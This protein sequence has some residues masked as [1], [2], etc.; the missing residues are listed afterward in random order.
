MET[1]HALLSFSGARSSMHRVSPSVIRRAI[2][3][4]LALVALAGCASPQRKISF[5][6]AGF[7]LA[8][9]PE[10]VGVPPP[11]QDPVPEAVASEAPQGPPIDPIL[12]RFASEARS[13]RWRHATPSPPHAG[14]ESRREGAFPTEAILAWRGLT[15]D[16][17]QYLRL[18]LP[19]TPLLELIRARVTLDAEWDYDR[20]RYGLPPREL[21]SEVLERAAR[22]SV[23]IQTVRALG[24]ALAAKSHPARMRWPVEQ[25]GISSM[26]GV[27][28]D[29]FDGMR[30]AHR[31]LDLAAEE[32][33]L[34]RAASGGWVVRAGPAG[35]YGLM[36]E[37]RHPGNVTT[38]YGHLSEI[39]CTPGDAIAAGQTLGLVGQ[40]GRATGPHL[41]FELWED[42]L[43]SDPLPWLSGER[44]ERVAEVPPPRRG[45]SSGGP[46]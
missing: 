35:G 26:F 6:D 37:L 3:P 11:V 5:A 30:H 43:A 16:L 22:L 32:G 24:A 41:H 28:I 44:V 25:A 8:P 27:R 2:R 13:R 15:A 33:E 39:L 4:A 23:R 29:P 31:G 38:R 42:G 21:E 36:V 10:E 14:G 1:A 20:R 7:Q 9:D 18:P 19:Q 46:R 12:L 45:A 17:D 34:V 40:T